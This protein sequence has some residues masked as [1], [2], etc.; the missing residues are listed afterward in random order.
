MDNAGGKNGEWKQQRPIGMVVK[1]ER[2]LVPSQGYRRDAHL[3]QGKILYG[4]E[5]LLAAQGH[6]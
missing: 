5:R 1:T 2:A 6:T 4:L 3:V